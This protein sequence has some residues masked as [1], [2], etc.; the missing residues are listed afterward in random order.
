MSFDWNVAAKANATQW[1]SLPAAGGSTNSHKINHT[2]SR[3]MGLMGLSATE[4]GGAP[5][6]AIDPEPGFFRRE[7]LGTKGE[8]ECETSTALW[9]TVDL[10]SPKW[11]RAGDET[12]W[13]IPD[14]IGPWDMNGFYERHDQL[15]DGSRGLTELPTILGAEATSFVSGLQNVRD[16]IHLGLQVLY[17]ASTTTYGIGR[18]VYNSAQSVGSTIAG[19]FS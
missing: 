13:W 3:S 5:G 17:S 10:G 7:L 16:P 12:I 6:A 19:W 1:S 15:W 8:G 2:D 4:C 9:G 14:K 11:P 18:A